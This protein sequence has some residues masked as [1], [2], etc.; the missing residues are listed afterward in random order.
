[1][2]E[3]AV[4]PVLDAV[5]PVVR[6]V[7]AHAR[8]II[9]EVVAT[10]GVASGAVQIGAAETERERAKRLKQRQVFSKLKDLNFKE[11]VRKNRHPSARLTKMGWARGHSC[12]PGVA[13]TN[14]T[15]KTKV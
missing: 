2:C 5:A 14:E 8:L 15:F 13:S 12:H 6:V 9:L 4:G 7:H 3:G 11:W 10:L 1:V